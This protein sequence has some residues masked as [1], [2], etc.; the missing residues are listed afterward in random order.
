MQ[1]IDSG[2]HLLLLDGGRAST[3]VVA[4]GTET[5]GVPAVNTSSNGIVIV[6]LKCQVGWSMPLRKVEASDG[7][8]DTDP[9][10][11]SW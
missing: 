9:E 10:E 4:L 6:R 11:R 8:A 3:N 1:E 7:D 2:L 5:K